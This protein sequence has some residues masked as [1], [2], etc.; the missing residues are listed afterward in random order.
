MSVRLFVSSLLS[1]TVHCRVPGFGEDY[2]L[3]CFV[4]I[5]SSCVLVAS[6]NN[7]VLDSKSAL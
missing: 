5:V 1:H 3:F 6:I 2:F 4:T 7:P